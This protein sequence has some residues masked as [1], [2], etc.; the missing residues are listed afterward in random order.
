MAKVVISVGSNIEPRKVHID[1]AINALKSLAKS[2]FRSAPI[3]ETEPKDMA[4][5]QYFLNTAVSFN[6]DL[7]PEQLLNELNQIERQSGRERKSN[8]VT[9]REIDLDILFYDELIHESPILT[10]PHPR[11]HVRNFVLVPL[12]DIEPDY[13][14]PFF[15]KA[16]WELYL[17]S[18]DRT[19]ILVYEVPK[20]N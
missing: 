10:I 16:I 15:K 19:E 3:Y 12:L 9:D 13:L 2:Q 8:L 11:L 1:R 20:S 5:D 4:S 18:Q 14:H 17:D 6:T 7:T